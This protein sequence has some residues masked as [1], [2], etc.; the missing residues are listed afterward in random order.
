MSHGTYMSRYIRPAGHVHGSN[1]H[2]GMVG[3]MPEHVGDIPEHFGDTS[4]HVGD[5]PEYVRDKSGHVGTY[6][7]GFVSKCG[8]K[9]IFLVG[10]VPFVEMR[11]DIFFPY[12]RNK[13]Y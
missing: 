2:V 10:H 1:G 7:K 4:E 12:F 5:M 9:V 11:P 3:D 8:L 6:L 13:D